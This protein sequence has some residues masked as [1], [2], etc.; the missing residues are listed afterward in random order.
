MSQIPSRQSPTGTTRPVVELT[1]MTP[2]EL[3]RHIQRPVQPQSEITE[4]TP[5]EKPAITPQA[6]ESEGSTLSDSEFTDVSSGKAATAAA[7]LC[8]GA[9][10]VTN[11]STPVDIDAH[12]SA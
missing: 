9:S 2:K 3:A 4:A 6:S 1:V 8:D 12:D 10:T 11:G 5:I 7:F